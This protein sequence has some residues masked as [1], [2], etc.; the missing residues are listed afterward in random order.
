MKKLFTSI[1]VASLAAGS[2]VQ[3]AVS[4]AIASALT[5]G[6]EDILAVSGAVP[7][8]IAAGMGL[9]AIVTVWIWSKRVPRKA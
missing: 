2:V 1:G 7:A 4:P 9:S 8:W 5:Q 3:A 6:S